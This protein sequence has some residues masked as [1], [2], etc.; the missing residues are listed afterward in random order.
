[1][2]TKERIDY[3]NIFMR[4]MASDKLYFVALHDHYSAQQR[5]N[6]RFMID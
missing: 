5:N 1:M 3:L 6:A 2:N 4:N